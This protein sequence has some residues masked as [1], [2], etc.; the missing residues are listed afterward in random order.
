MQGLPDYLGTACWPMAV[1]S[2]PNIKSLDL[3]VTAIG[4]ALQLLLGFPATI[5]ILYRAEVHFKIST[6]LCPVDLIGCSRCGAPCLATH[7]CLHIM[8]ASAA[9]TRV[10]MSVHV[11]LLHAFSLTL[12]LAVLTPM[13]TLFLYL[14]PCSPSFCFSAPLISSFALF[15][16][17][18][19]PPHFS[20]PFVIV[21]NPLISFCSPIS[22][23][24]LSLSSLSLPHPSLDVPHSSFPVPHF[25][26]VFLISTWPLYISLTPL[27]L[28]D[29]PSLSLCPYLSLCCSIDIYV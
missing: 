13:C 6:H 28:S 18:L 2:L 23:F 20:L 16:L 10:Y 21:S 4:S 11:P 8:P 3:S 14:S 22:L 27:L 26:C 19:Y 24:F 12:S 15:H 17:W 25:L 5:T 7:I 29:P 1:R 9:S